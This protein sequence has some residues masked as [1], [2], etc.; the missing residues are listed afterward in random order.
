MLSGFPGPLVTHGIDLFPAEDG[1]SVTI[2]AVNHL[3]NPDYND[4]QAGNT[5]QY[6]ARS[7]VEVFSHDVGSDTA[8]WIRS[9]QNPQIRTPNDIFATSP[10]SFYVTNDHHYRDGALRFIEDLLEYNTG[11]WSD[12][13]HVS[14]TPNSPDATSGITSTIALPKAHNP[15]GLGHS[16]H[17]DEVLLTSAAGGELYIMHRDSET[18]ALSLRERIQ[19]DSTIDNPSYY[20][21]VYATPGN[22]A[23]GYLLAGLT[24]AHA[25]ADVVAKD[26]TPI[27][28]IV[29]HVRTNAGGEQEKAVLFENDGRALRSASAAVLVG[30]DPKENSGRKQAWLFVTGFVSQSMV[31]V[32][33]D[34]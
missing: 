16:A 25:L 15:N 14:F 19:L 31:A 3:P 4:A 6:K 20:E 11:A 23:S 7:H 21:D 18:N 33:V 5:T 22:N 32:K 27:P 8:V 24:V 30:I 2:F 28:V 29:W 9:V 10:T 1:Q 34:L 13:V 12:V 17:A 26:E